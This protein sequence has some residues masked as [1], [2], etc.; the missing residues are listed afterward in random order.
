MSLI[1]YLGS[2]LGA[3]GEGASG[4]RVRSAW[5]KFKVLSPIMNVR[6]A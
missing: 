2:M 3:G 6:G 1:C 4:T 5:D